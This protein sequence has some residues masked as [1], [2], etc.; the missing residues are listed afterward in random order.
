VDIIDRHF[1]AE[2]SHDVAATLATYADDVVWD[3][4]AHPLCPVRGKPAAGLMYEG[5]MAAI[6][7]LHLAPVSRFS[8]GAHVVD[9]SLATGHVEG[10]FLGAAGGGAPVSFR[11]LHVFDVTGELITREQAWFDSAGVLRQIAEHAIRTADG[12]TVG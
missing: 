3:D 10:N 4:V 7:D 1:T 2:N 5:I 6:P 12:H 9:E 11:M 8:C